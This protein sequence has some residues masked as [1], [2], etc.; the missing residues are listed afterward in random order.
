VV[1]VGGGISGLSAA[2]TIA[3][4]RK[5]GT[6]VELTL[7]EA[8]SRLGGVIQSERVEGCSVEAGPDSFLVE[9]PEAAALA[10]ELG[11]GDLLTSSNDR[12]RRTYILHHGKLC[13]LPDGLMLLVPTR[14]WPVVSTPLLPLSSKL[15][16]AGEWFARPRRDAPEDESVADFVTRHFGRALLDNIADPL[17]AGVYGGDSGRL[18]M[19]SV[20]ARFWKMEREDGSL[21]RATLRAV[22]QRRSSSSSTPP[23]F[24]T[25]RGGLSLLTGKLASELDPSGIW[26]GRRAQMIERKGSVYQV[27]LDDGMA[28]DADAVILSLPAHAASRLLTSLSAKLAGLLA[29]IPYSSAMTVSLGFRSEDVAGLPAGFGFL[30][31]A[32]EGRRLLAC[33][34][35]DR[36]FPGSAPEGKALVRCFMG[37]SRDPEV[38]G[39]SDA[40]ALAIVRRELDEILGLKAEPLFARIHRWPNS[41]AQYTVGHEAR[42]HAIEAELEKLPGIY[43]SGNAYSGIGISDCI[44]TGKAAAESAC[45]LPTA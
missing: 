8:A 36:K 23:L 4:A 17:L 14:L 7:L 28:F 20:L 39:V 33:T 21:T 15:A 16:M 35:V 2:Y 43:V 40:E 19:R 18:S 1:V 27:K 34:F 22:R 31:P 25:L 11:L 37:G 29:E 32:K 24:M 5:A 26:L 10:R 30:V 42:V 44:R 3:R 41:M 38:L 45:R 13:P 12:E 9:K 6:Q